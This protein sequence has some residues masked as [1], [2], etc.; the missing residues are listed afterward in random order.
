MWN[1]GCMDFMVSGSRSVKESDPGLAIIS[2]GPKFLLES[3]LEG[4]V[5]L[6]Y[7]AFT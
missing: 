6:K 2:K 5:D 1:T 7:F 4:C 3:F